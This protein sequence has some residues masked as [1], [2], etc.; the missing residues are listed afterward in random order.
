MERRLVSH[1]DTIDAFIESHAQNIRALS[2][3]PGLQDE[4]NRC[5]AS[6]DAA[7]T[8]ERLNAALSDAR[9]RIQVIVLQDESE[10]PR[11]DDG[12]VIWGHAGTYV[13]VFAL[14]EEIGSWESNRSIVARLFH[15]I[16]ARSTRS[17]QL[18]DMEMART[19]L[20]TSLSPAEIADNLQERFEDGNLQIENE[21]ERYGGIQN[22][23]LRDEFVALTFERHP[24][25]LNRDYATS[26]MPREQS[27]SAKV[28]ILIASPSAAGKDELFRR[29]KQDL[30]DEVVIVRRTTSRKMRRIQQFDSDL[31]FTTSDE[32]LASR[33]RGELAM[34]E[35]NYGGRLYAVTEEEV[36]R[37]LAAG[38][39]VVV[40]VNPYEGR[41]SFLEHYPN[42][43]SLFISPLGE[44]ECAGFKPGAM[45]AD[46]EFSRKALA[47]V[48]RGSIESRGRDDMD[49]DVRVRRGL[50]DMERIYEFD[51]VLYNDRDPMGKGGRLFAANYKNFRRMIL[52]LAKGPLTP[53]SPANT[54]DRAREIA[55]FGTMDV[56]AKR[57]LFV[58]WL[59]TNY[60]GSED[61]I[62]AVMDLDDDE[63]AAL[64]TPIY[65]VFVSEDT[66]SPVT[67][68][69]EDGIL[70]INESVISGVPGEKTDFA[71]EAIRREMAKKL[72][73]L[74]S[75]IEWQSNL[76]IFPQKNINPRTL[77]KEEAARAP[78][79]LLTDIKNGKFNELSPR[80]QEI[81]LR[82]LTDIGRR[83]FFT[84]MR[85]GVRSPDWY[86]RRLCQ[87]A[88]SQIRSEDI[89]GLGAGELRG[90]L[91]DGILD[92]KI[93]QV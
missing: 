89:A 23:F 59:K 7:E 37:H 19:D 17:K 26:T 58:S 65:R 66:D 55:L 64:F 44:A 62:D 49:V 16:R 47:A 20:G 51:A 27:F 71:R 11:L 83:G 4:F 70:L 88:L 13:T 91:A 61:L 48:V 92:P 43:V 33:E 31:V 87:E 28:P 69:L 3:I 22:V 35:E 57:D 67:V 38:K 86:V 14:A 10:L 15:E 21:V 45:P 30:G 5:V 52:D 25:P 77:S 9:A 60:S 6:S 75:G 29:L 80:I 1:Q 81:A 84:V 12:T 54:I 82:L 24:S 85:E 73:G 50:R 32:I 90:M 36:D 63:T 79:Q 56:V 41:Q 2:E 76:Y 34:F 74:H 46:K 72:P 53:R 93:G 8:I 39:I 42:A 68:M 78:I 18:F 40:V